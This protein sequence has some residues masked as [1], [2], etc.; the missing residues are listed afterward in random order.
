MSLNHVPVAYPD[1][2]PTVI[3]MAGHG[4]EFWRVANASADTILDL[5][6]VY[7][8]AVQPL[9]IVALDG[10]PTG[11][12]DGTRRGKGFRVSHILLSP[13]GRAEFVIPAL[14]PGIT[15]AVFQTVKADTGPGGDNG[16]DPGACQDF[17]G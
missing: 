4:R 3:R 16:P 10:V 14:P 13:A 11:S 12:Q 6:L 9:D 2:K 5:Q 1:F 15:N 17:H 8:G 7:G